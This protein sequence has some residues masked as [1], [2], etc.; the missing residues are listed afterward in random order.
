MRSEGFGQPGPPP[1][2]FTAP[3]SEAGRGGPCV[4]R[5]AAVAAAAMEDLGPGRHM[6]EVAAV[7]DHLLHP[8]RIAVAGRAKAGK[9]TL[10]N[11][12]VGQRVAP[13]AVEE[14]TKV[15]TWF[16]YGVPERVEVVLRDGTRKALPLQDGKIPD[17]LGPELASVDHI[18][19]YLSSEKLRDVTLIDTPG[20]ASLNE[21]L[22]DRTEAMLVDR[23]SR[24]AVR[25]ADALVFLI[26]HGARQDDADA[27]E[28]F[29]SLFAGTEASPAT[30][31]AVL[32]RADQIGGGEK[33][34]LALA[35]RI[36]TRQADALRSVASTVV[37]VAGLLAE[38]AG[39]QALEERDM[40]ALEAL[41]CLS[42]ETRTMM[43]FS[44]EDLTEADVPVSVEQ[45]QRLAGLLDL[46]G[47][48]L[49]L[50]LVDGGVR[51]AASL[52]AELGRVCGVERLSSLLDETFAQRADALKASSALSALSRI[53]W[54]AADAGS[55]PAL[56]ELRDNV[57]DL[58]LEPEMRVIA[59]IWAA[60][61]AASPETLLPESLEADVVRLT[62]ES[63]VPRRL[64]LESGASAS[65]M[66]DAARDGVARWRRFANLEAATE[67]ETRVARIMYRS[68]EA[69]SGPVERSA[70][71]RGSL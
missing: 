1:V 6:Q 14:C 10:V 8:L 63:T 9:S 50:E 69:M 31:V 40:R 59:E 70:A 49:A 25:Q 62:T 34:P 29:G 68:F 39:T 67:L 23:S 60:Q 54:Q 12:L 18:H 22:S 47:L 5:V 65:D 46:F 27:L 7:R 64:G 58:R 44:H 71:T 15:V 61:A 20:L 36:A 19:V 35:E 26:G 45:R 42:P 51:G 2:A 37:P 24:G 66:A 53:S 17:P 55:A 16:S 32:S 4:A 56:R 33:D 41:A 38:T 30:A 43:L 13:T 28:A 48:Q 3:M 11:A 57:E 52:E 21:E